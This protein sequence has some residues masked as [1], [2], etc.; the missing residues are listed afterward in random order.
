MIDKPVLIIGGGGHAKVL[1]DCLFLNEAEITGFTDLDSLKKESLAA[2]GIKFLGNDDQ[3]FE[4]EPAQVLLVNG[5]GGV[6]KL[7]IRGSIYSSFKEKGYTFTQVIHPAATIASQVIIEEGAQ[8]MAG[9]VIQPGS[10]IGANSI[11]NT[12]AMIDHE[13]HIGRNVH[14]APGAVLSGAVL[15]GDN[16]FIGAGSTV[17]QCVQIGKKVIVG[18]AS[19][20]NSNIPDYAKAYG[21][22]AKVVKT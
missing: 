1:V 16:T 6:G 17:M 7:S 12:G 10:F 9:A 11:I 14:I 8:V 2:Y 3:I 4:Y 22:P 21:V 15:V 19:I 18:A 13:C 5:L 20:V